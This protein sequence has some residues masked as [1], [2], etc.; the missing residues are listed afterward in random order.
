[1]TRRS[2]LPVAVRAALIP[3]A[4]LFVLAGCERK[5]APPAPPPQQVG[6]VTLKTQAVQLH[7]QLPGRTEAYEI[8]QVRPQV[9][10][11]I[12]KRL[13]VEGSDV[14]AGQQLYQID[15]SFYQSTYDSYLGQLAAAKA[16]LVTA[17]AKYQRYQSLIREH[18]IS[19]QE[20]DDAK[21]T[22]LADQAQV[23]VA[24]GQVENAAVN[25]RYTK[26]NAPI[27]G[28]IGRSVITVGALATAGQTNLLTTVTR[29]DPI[30]VDVNLPAVE[31]L[32]FRRELASGQIERAGDNAATVKLT[33]EDGSSY[34]LPGTLEFSEVNVDTATSTIVVRAKFSNPDKLLLPGMY[35]HATL[36]EGMDPNA[37]LVPQQ[38]VS[39]DA[40]DAPQVMV[41]TSDNKVAVRTITTQQALGTDWIVTGGVAA[42]DR[43]IVTGLQKIHPGDKTTPV[44]FVDDETTKSGN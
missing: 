32:R 17:Q 39:R 19:Q 43:V 24:Q 16:N 41:L 13:F 34:S 29:L 1:M 30:F 37:L 28:R 18:A 33:L 26:V 23:Q 2:R 40:H 22:Y 35:V 9:N 42:G 10:G 25:L 15:P 21:A 4:G 7:T 31:L 8:A 12:Q 27:S 3:T 5:H 38:A 36:D 11:V 44:P 6:F 14:T 20:L